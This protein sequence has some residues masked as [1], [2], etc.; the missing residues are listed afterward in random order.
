MSLIPTR[1]YSLLTTHYS[2]KMSE[3]TVAARY[4]KAL[5]DLAQEQNAVE[6]M[7]NDMGLFHH[8][9]R[10]NPELKAV[11]A[12]PIVSHS[13]KI[14]ILDEVFSGKVNKAS[15]TF[16]K[17]MVNKSRGEVLYGTS[18]EYINMYDVKNHIIHANVV[19]ATA[20]SAENK[21][22]MVADIQAAT[23]GTIKLNTKTD[24][25]LIGGFVLTVGDREVD[26][27]IASDLKKLKKEFAKRVITI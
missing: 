14:K 24:A 17:L 18:Q 8:T 21:K 9:L 10:A 19:S 16:F 6:E 11:L 2:L 4:A 23:G 27:S 5:I 15:I 3:I 13:K 1:H 22:K 26:T 25:S 7:K 12:N 20:L